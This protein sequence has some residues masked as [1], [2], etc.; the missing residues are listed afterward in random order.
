MFV[1]GSSTL[2]IGRNVAN[3]IDVITI[4]VNKGKFC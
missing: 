1:D 4:T 2:I 3:T